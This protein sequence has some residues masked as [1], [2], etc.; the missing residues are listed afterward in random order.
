MNSR[1]CNDTSSCT[2]HERAR[3]EAR[4]VRRL[5]SRDLVVAQQRARDVV[6][7][8]HERLLRVRVELERDAQPVGMRDRQALE[9]DGQLVARGD[10][11]PELA[12][13]APAVTTIG[14]SPVLIAFVRK[15]SPNDGA[16]TTR[17]P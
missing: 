6:E 11:P 17:K 9:V 14:A 2:L 15:M 12:R 10:A 4:R 16:I 13:A 7:A 3:V 8:V 5:E 1:S